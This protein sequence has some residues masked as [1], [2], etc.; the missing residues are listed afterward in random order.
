MTRTSSAIQDH[1][2][3]RRRRGSLLLALLAS[4]FMVSAPLQAAPA[5]KDVKENCLE[6]HGEKDFTKDAPK[7]TTLSL[8][9]DA[10]RFGKAVHASLTCKSCHAD[11]NKD[12]PGDGNPPPKVN[13]G[14]CH[15]EEANIYQGSI[16]GMSKAMG[17]SAAA[18]CVDCHGNHYISPVKQSDSPV[19]KMNLPKT[20]AKCHANKNLTD[21]YKMK[22]PS[23]GSQ[24]Q[25][26]IH[27]QALLKKGL[28]VATCKAFI[29][30]SGWAGG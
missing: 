25:E 11:M 23:V 7:G 14:S 1:V 13:C 2:S 24:Y 4:I 5:K 3:A 21:E 28:I 6:C 19:Y 30:T 10:A 22:Y 17:S 26:S 27:G 29:F 16:H 20:C 15:T 18:N 8:F 9:V 12:H